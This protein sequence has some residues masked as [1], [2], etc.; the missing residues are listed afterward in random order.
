MPEHSIPEKSGWHRFHWSQDK[1][2]AAREVGAETVCSRIAV[3][4]LIPEALLAGIKLLRLFCR[5]AKTGD[6]PADHDFDHFTQGRAY[7]CYAR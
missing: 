7:R 4:I 3:L 5:I 2:S 1:K 6:D